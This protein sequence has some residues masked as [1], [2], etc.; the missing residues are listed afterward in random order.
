MSFKTIAS[1]SAVALVVAGLASAQPSGIAVA[2]LGEV[3]PLEVSAGGNLPDPVW[4][5]GDARALR[6]VLETL[7]ASNDRAWDNSPAAEAG[8]SSKPSGVAIVSCAS[9][10]MS[11]QRRTPPCWLDFFFTKRLDFQ[12]VFHNM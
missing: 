7:P 12:I 10:S 6:A 2:E 5:S 3:K 4:S 11:P 9:E 8:T 1:A